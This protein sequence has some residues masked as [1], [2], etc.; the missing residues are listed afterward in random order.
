[1]KILSSIL[2]QFSK[3]IMEGKIIKEKMKASG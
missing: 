3:I 1:M 2:L